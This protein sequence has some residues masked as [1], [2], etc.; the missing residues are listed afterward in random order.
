MFVDRFVYLVAPKFPSRHCLR[1][2]ARDLVRGPNHALPERLVY[3]F[4]GNIPVR[5]GHAKGRLDAAHRRFRAL[6][7]R[8][9][10]VAAYRIVILADVRDYVVW[11]YACHRPK[12]TL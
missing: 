1:L 3:G 5:R 11:S 10:A 6:M 4:N 12:S 2:S 8:N 9:H 7:H